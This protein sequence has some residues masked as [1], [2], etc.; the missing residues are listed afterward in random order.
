MVLAGC[1]CLFR[2]REAVLGKVLGGGC[3]GGR[4]HFLVQA[5]PGYRANKKPDVVCMRRGCYGA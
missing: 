3:R 2:D 4:G 5:V 1:R